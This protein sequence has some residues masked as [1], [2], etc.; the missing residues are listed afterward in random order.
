MLMSAV[1]LAIEVFVYV[2][3]GEILPPFLRLRMAYYGGYGKVRVSGK[4]Q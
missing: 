4:K 3:A 1:V 2:A